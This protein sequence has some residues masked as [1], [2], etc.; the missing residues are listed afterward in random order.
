MG[1][2][3]LVVYTN[4]VQSSL[5]TSSYGKSLH[6]RQVLSNQCKWM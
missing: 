5:C 6:G 4:S 1:D 2:A 3:G